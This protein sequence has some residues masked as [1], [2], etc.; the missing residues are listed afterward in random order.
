MRVKSS[1]RFRVLLMSRAPRVHLEVVHSLRRADAEVRI[2]TGPAR[3]LA[4]L[5]HAP[6][7]VLVD[8]AHGAGL[9]TTVVR[10]LNRPR[11]ATLVLAMHEGNL[12]H[13]EPAV[14]QLCVDGYC[15]PSDLIGR[16]ALAGSAVLPQSPLLH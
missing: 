10:M 3:A 13:A 6:E 5:R 8:L 11:G 12:E 9:N 16:M 7:L 1:P 15:R 14:S 2:A 4:L